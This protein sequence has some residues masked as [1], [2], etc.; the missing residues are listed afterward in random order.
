[1]KI[2]VEKSVSR[3]VDKADLIWK[4]FYSS[5]RYCG[6]QD[7][8]IKRIMVVLRYMLSAVMGYLLLNFTRN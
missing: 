4:W 2:N 7:A 1:M 8:K 5:V 6:N 3:L